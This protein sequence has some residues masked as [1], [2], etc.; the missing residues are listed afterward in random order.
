MPEWSSLIPSSAALTSIPSLS[1]PLRFVARR[2]SSDIAGSVAPGSAKADFIPSARF[3]APHTIARDTEPSSTVA[4]LSLSA[5]GW[6]LTSVTPA[7]TT[8]DTPEPSLWT[9][10]TSLPDME[11]RSASSSGESSIS[12]YSRSHS[13]DTF[14]PYS[15][16]LE[17]QL[18]L[19]QEARVVLEEDP[20]VFYPV[21]QHRHTLDTNPEREAGILLLVIT[22]VLE[23]VGVYHHAAQY[24]QPVSYTHM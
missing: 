11:S 24:L 8:P 10:S 5:F 3:G 14:N 21:L 13:S 16:Y 22:D 17:N 15:S 7:T 12:T 9:L 20:H 6:G 4:T 2:G 23:N 18:E 19:A 1:N